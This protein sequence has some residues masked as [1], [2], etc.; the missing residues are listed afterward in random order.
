MAAHRGRIRSVMM[1]V[2][3]AFDFHAGVQPR[4]PRWMQQWGLEWLHR[5][6]ND[7]RR[8]WRRYLFTN[9]PFLIMA[10]AQWL[11]SRLT[12]ARP[13]RVPAREALTHV[14]APYKGA[15]E[16]GTSAANKESRQATDMR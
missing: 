4:A 11:A 7:P 3:A 9:S 15:R 2:G 12:G 10:G 14:D 16:V 5:L 6:L 1:G 8:L 13:A